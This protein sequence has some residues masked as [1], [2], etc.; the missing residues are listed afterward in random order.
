MAPRGVLLIYHRP[1]KI[2][3]ENIAIH[4]KQSNEA[5]KDVLFIYKSLE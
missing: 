1:R 2:W 5:I 4:L 3:P